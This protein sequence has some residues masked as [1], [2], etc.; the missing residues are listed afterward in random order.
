MISGLDS[1]ETSAI[2]KTPSNEFSFFFTG[3]LSREIENHW[4]HGSGYE[5]TESSAS[6]RQR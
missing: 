6:A 3:L 5:V 4:Q 1:I 2:L